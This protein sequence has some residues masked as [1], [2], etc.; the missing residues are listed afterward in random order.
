MV[1]RRGETLT[2]LSA[3]DTDRVAVWCKARGLVLALEAFAENRTDCASG[4]VFVEPFT[5]PKGGTDP[6]RVPPPASCKA[7]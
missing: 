4:R 5:R 7:P 6:L 2:A 1:A 3:G